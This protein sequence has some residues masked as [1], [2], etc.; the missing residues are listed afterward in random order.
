MNNSLLYYMI[1]KRK[2]KQKK[3]EEQ[4]NYPKERKSTLK[5]LF[6]GNTETRGD[7]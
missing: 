5:T 3:E 7:L 6:L 4:L 1:C 2:E